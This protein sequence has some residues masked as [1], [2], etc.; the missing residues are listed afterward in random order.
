MALGEAPVDD[1]IAVLEAGMAENDY[2]INTLFM[3][4]CAVLVILMQ[5]GFAMLEVGLNSQK[6]TVN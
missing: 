2:V 4:L 6:N 3:M 5:P 1:K